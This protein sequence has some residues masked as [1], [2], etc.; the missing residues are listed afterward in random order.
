M[1]DEKAVE[2]YTEYRIETKKP[3]QRSWKFLPFT[4][5]RTSRW[6]LVRETMHQ[7]AEMAPAG[8]R[9]RIVSRE[10]TVQRTSWD[11]IGEETK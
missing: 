9:F 10:V 1:L 4:G 7:Q 2:T 5:A 11:P 6:P 8:W 3:R